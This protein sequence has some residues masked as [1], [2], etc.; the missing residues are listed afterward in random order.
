[1]WA[2]LTIVMWL[3]DATPEVHAVLVIGRACSGDL[4]DAVF[5]QLISESDHKERL[6]T[7]YA[8][9][10]DEAQAPDDLE[11]VVPQ[12]PHDATPTMPPIFD[13]TVSITSSSQQST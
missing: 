4:A 6:T 5:T 13:Q 12:V 8:Y 11:P 9:D 7:S 1:M 10:C 2:V 3:I